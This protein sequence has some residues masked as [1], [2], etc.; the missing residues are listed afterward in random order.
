MVKYLGLYLETRFN[1]NIHIIKTYASLFKLYPHINR[2]T[3]L[4]NECTI[5]LYKTLIR[6]TLTYSSPVWYGTK[7]TN[8]DKLQRLQNKILRI[9]VDAPWFVRN[10]QIHGHLPYMTLLLHSQISLEAST[11]D[12]STTF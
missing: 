8:Y 6:P 3:P 7:T 10:S 1:Q 11:C 2:R 9:S 4:K 5:I 12:R